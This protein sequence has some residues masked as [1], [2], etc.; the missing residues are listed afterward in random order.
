LKAD[1]SDNTIDAALTDIEYASNCARVAD[2]RSSD[3]QM[4]GNGFAT[5]FAR[6]AFYGITSGLIT[7]KSLECSR[8]ARFS[9]RSVRK[10]NFEIKARNTCAIA[11]V[12]C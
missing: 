1:F 5:G 2:I 8:N 7:P 6:T 4:A 3:A 10:A 12:S 11:Q 9:R